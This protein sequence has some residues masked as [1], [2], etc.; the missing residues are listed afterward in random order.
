M[1]S[2]QPKEAATAPS[3]WIT[4]AR[5]PL[6]LLAVGLVIYGALRWIAPDVN[7][8]DFVNVIGLGAVLGAAMIELALRKWRK[9]GG[10]NGA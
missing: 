3:L 7:P 2:L 9:K 1:S 8:A 4:V 5:T 10:S 6:L